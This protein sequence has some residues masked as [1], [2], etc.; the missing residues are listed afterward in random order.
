V[1]ACAQPTH[2]PVYDPNMP[3]EQNEQHKL[4]PKR[5]HERAGAPQILL[6]Q[7]ARWLN[8][9]SANDKEPQAQ[10]RC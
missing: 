5:I 9:A 7:F 2:G 6:M 4:L 3:E 10:Y 1:F 8:T